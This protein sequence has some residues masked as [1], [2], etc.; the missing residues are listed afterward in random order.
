MTSKFREP[1]ELSDNDI[2][3]RDRIIEEIK[4]RTGSNIVNIIVYKENQLIEPRTIRPTQIIIE[5]RVGNQYTRVIYSEDE[6]GL[7]NRAIY[8]GM[9]ESVNKIISVLIKAGAQALC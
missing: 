2:Q 3:Y 1:V 8:Y 5:C 7:N 9:R 6:L 4:A